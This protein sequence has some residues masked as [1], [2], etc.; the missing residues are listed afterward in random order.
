MVLGYFYSNGLGELTMITLELKQ[1]WKILKK[2]NKISFLYNNVHMT[3]TYM[4]R[5]RTP[6]FYVPIWNQYEVVLIE[7][8]K[9]FDKKVVLKGTGP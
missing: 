8:G 4:S 7:T 1:L 6:T 2:S 9:Y 5:R 3:M